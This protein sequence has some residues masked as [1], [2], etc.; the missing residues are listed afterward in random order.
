MD[1]FKI[2]PIDLDVHLSERVLSKAAY[3]DYKANEN[4]FRTEKELQEIK[5][6]F[7][8]E[9]ANVML[10]SEVDLNSIKKFAVDPKY[11][12]GHWDLFGNLSNQRGSNIV[13]LIKKGIPLDISFETH[14]HA[15]MRDENGNE[16]PLFMR[17]VPAIIIKKPNERKDERKDGSKDDEVI[18]EVVILLGVHA[19]SMRTYDKKDPKSQMR[20]TAEFEG[21]R[22]IQ[23]MYREQYGPDTKFIIQGDFNTDTQMP[24]EYAALKRGFASFLDIL[25][26]PF[27]HED[28]VTHTYHKRD[29][30]GRYLYSNKLQLDDILVDW[31][32]TKYFVNGYVYRYLDANGTRKPLPRTLE[33]R[34][35]NLSDHFPVVSVFD[36]FSLFF[37]K[38]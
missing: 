17:D 6:L 11:L 3:V 18:P 19:K 29:D 2:K 24:N 10:L 38:D 15:K 14:L 27:G 8:K 7:F 5:E 23:D 16:V 30:S 26:V 31:S 36:F 32:L 22:L 37:G 21:I 9:D 34:D 28:R 12:N 20:R 13:Y 25:R 4:R 35:Q 1:H 33:E